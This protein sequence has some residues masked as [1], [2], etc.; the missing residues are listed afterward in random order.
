MLYIVFSSAADIPP[1]MI[2]RAPGTR[3]SHADRRPHIPAP[4]EARIDLISALSKGFNKEIRIRFDGLSLLWTHRRK[5][6]NL[7]DGDLYRKGYEVV[8]SW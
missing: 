2:H 6:D 3:H 5:I 8:V 7:V 4:K 1:P